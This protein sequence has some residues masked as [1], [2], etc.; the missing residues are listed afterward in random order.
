MAGV[1]VCARGGGGYK[2]VLCECLFILDGRTEQQQQRGGGGRPGENV[3]VLTVWSSP[4]K[5]Y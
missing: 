3:K 1:K 5:S 2:Q 4:K